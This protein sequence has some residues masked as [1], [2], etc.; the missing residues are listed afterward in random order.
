MLLL[1]SECK[2]HNSNKSVGLI[3][4]VSGIKSLE[5]TM[6]SKATHKTE[7]TFNFRL[8]SG[9]YMVI[10]QISTWTSELDGTLT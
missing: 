1:I 8:N 10:H 5:I 3:C 6:D 7:R 4:L 2:A 9:K